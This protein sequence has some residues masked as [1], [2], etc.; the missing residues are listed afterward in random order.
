MRRRRSRSLLVPITLICVALLQVFFLTF[1]GGGAHGSAESELDR[2]TQRLLQNAK[3][4]EVRAETQARVL[5]E[6]L[7]VLRS[8]MSWMRRMMGEG[9]VHLQQVAVDEVHTAYPLIEPRLLL[10]VKTLV[11]REVITTFDNATHTF[12]V[13]ERIDFDFEDKKCFLLLAES[14]RGRA[15][16]HMGCKPASRLTAEAL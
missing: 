12:S 9:Y 1:P 10:S 5:A 11:G 7:A 4:A 2:G 14:E 3:A 8:E 16:F 6:E 15:L 13:G